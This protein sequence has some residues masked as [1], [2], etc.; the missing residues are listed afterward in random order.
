M[1][2][3]VHPRGSPQHTALVTR[4][5]AQVEKDS[6]SLSGGLLQPFGKQLLAGLS[7]AELEKQASWC[8]GCSMAG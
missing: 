1:T 4:F 8:C 3:L 7:N 6:D 2:D 5:R